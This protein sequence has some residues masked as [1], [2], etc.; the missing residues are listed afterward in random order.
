MFV[1]FRKLKC[2]KISY[3]LNP[4]AMKQILILSLY[5]II[6]LSVFNSAF[7]QI[8]SQ[9][10]PVMYS[11]LAWEDFN[12][13]GFEDLLLTGRNMDEGVISK[14]YKNNGDGTFTD[15]NADI[16]GVYNGSV[17]WGDYD[18]DGFSDILLTGEYIDESYN[19]IKVSKIY[20]NNG[21]ETFT[22]IN[23]ELTAVLNSS[24]A[25]GDYNNDT[26]PDI[27]LTGNLGSEYFPEGI[28]KIYKNNGDGTFT[29]QTMINLTDV[30]NSS[31]AF[32]DYNNDTYLDI[33]LTGRNNSNEH[34]SLI[35]SN[36]TDGTF[37]E[38]NTA[39]LPGIYKGSVAWNDYNNDGNIDILLAGYYYSGY[40]TL[41]SKIYKN[42]GDSTFSDIDAGLQ[43]VYNSSV[44]W[45][46]YNNDN[47]PDI[48][49]TGNNFSDNTFSKIYKNN[50]DDTFTEQMQFNI[51]DVSYSSATWCDYDN[52]GNLDFIISG[53][54]EC[55]NTKGICKLYKNNGIDGFSSGS[56]EYPNGFHSIETIIKVSKSS[57]SWSDYNNDGN[58]D[59]LLTGEDKDYN[60]FSKIY[61]NN[62]DET[63]SDINAGI[64][65]VIF[66]LTDWDDYNNDTFQDVLFIGEDE[67]D[68]YI[69]KI[70]KNNG[71][72]T[73]VDINAGLQSV[74]QG[75]AV[76]G[77]YNN[78][79]LPDILL[80]GNYYDG[81]QQYIT[82]I[83]KNN[84]NNSFSEI[85]AGL[86]GI[87]GG[88]AKWGD[89]NNDGYLDIFVSGGYNDGTWHPILKL[90]KNNNGNGTF[91]EINI[92]LTEFYGDKIEWC[93]YNNDNYLDILLTGQYNNE[94]LTKLYKNNN[95]NGTFSEIN[96]N[97][98]GV[99]DG[100]IDWGDYNNDGLKDI[101]ITGNNYEKGYIAKIY[102]NNGDD[103]FTEIDT[104]MQ[105]VMNGMAKWGNYNNDSFLDIILTGYNNGNRITEIYRNNGNETFTG[106]TGI[107]PNFTQISESYGAWGDYD[108]NNYQDLIL[109]G[110]AINDSSVTD[111][112]SNFEKEFVKAEI[113]VPVLNQ[114]SNQW[115][116]FNNDGYLDLLLTG[117]N[118]LD[119]PVT[120]IYQ[121]GG[122]SVFINSNISIEGI[123]NSST[124]WADY[125]NDG[126]QDLLIAGKNVQGNYITKLYKNTRNN[127][128][129]EAFIAF[130]GASK[131]KWA[132]V[133]NDNKTDILLFSQNNII[134]YENLGNDAFEYSGKINDGWFSILGMEIWDINNDGLTDVLTDKEIILNTGNSNF[135]HWRTLYTYS[136][137]IQSYDYNNSGLPKLVFKT[138]TVNESPAT[139]FYTVNYPEGLISNLVLPQM[140]D[141]DFLISDWDNDRDLDYILSGKDQSGNPYTQLFKNSLSEPD[142][143]PSS[144]T[145]LNFSCNE[146]VVH[147]SWN[148]ATD[149]ETPQNSLTY[150]CY[151]YEIGG[152]T[153]WHSLSNQGTGINNG[154][155][156]IPKEGNVGHNTS[157]FINGLDVTKKYAWSV[158]AIDYTFEGSP[159][160]PE[161]T[162]RLAPAYTLQPENKT[163]CQNSDVIIRIT[164]TG[165]DTYQ[166]QVNNGTGFTNIENNE[167]YNNATTSDLSINGATLEMNNYQFRCAATT[168]GG[169]TYSNPA[170]LTV[171][172]LILANAGE[173]AGVCV[174]TELQLSAENPESAEGTWSCNV[175]Q[176]TFSDI[177]APDA[178]V[179]NL[180]Q[181]STN[182][183]WKITQDNVCGSNTDIVVITQNPDGVLPD[184]SAKPDGE[185]ELCIGS[186]SKLNT[187]GANNALSYIWEITPS[188]AGIISETGTNVTAYWNSNYSGTASIKVQAENECGTGNWSDNFDVELK[189]IQVHD[190]LQKSETM[191]ISVDSGYNYQWYYNE[192][193]ITGATKQYYYNE[194]L[195]SGNYQIKISFYD[196]CDKL[197]SVFETTESNK[198]LPLDKTITIFP[199]PTD[200]NITIEIDNDYIGSI[201]MII[202]DNLGRKRKENIF[203][204]NQKSIRYNKKLSDLE[205]GTY[206]IEFIFDNI[207]LSKQLIIK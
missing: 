180:P 124:D 136:N 33:L 51:T 142:N 190:I 154:K 134:L 9:F 148:K 172:T 139:I 83:Y 46:D 207:K 167:I 164:T 102:K 48:L 60:I 143:I 166:W 88:D 151:M 13:D 98:T 202:T 199:N 189:D 94:S 107:I 111:I 42:N 177:H 89:Y 150:N 141:K 61:K 40:G 175:Q 20:K 117:K 65:G 101:L 97:I 126:F 119:V 73:F 16:Q 159:F 176:V 147:I 50:G 54:Y 100:S 21:N 205:I 30:H 43:V 87:S 182:L 179:Y 206:L 96:T 35:Y 145:G 2:L 92:G 49:L 58:L 128:F 184:K 152:D 8:P 70:Y 31:V 68:N 91:S 170:V 24:V 133:N 28:S 116:D 173:D 186:T 15:I 62:G 69:T 122:N 39:D 131:V 127:N 47:Y 59:F 174:S 157:W 1:L 77:D 123:Y 105:G 132:D 156:Y 200:G 183:E 130:P 90:Y 34:V 169:T 99:N 197:S 80:T 64:Q 66:G 153:I 37:T 14:I 144:P 6:Q 106:I 5:I 204:K 137:E 67:N 7:S 110:V 193:A 95:G 188:E 165:A 26:Y 22:D 4:H 168:V 53:N 32:G 12:N 196:G 108:K 18:K 158:Q 52:D 29:E 17:A 121:N 104:D 114:G 138:D 192:S 163:I 113:T 71:D 36:N 198:S 185:T 194:N 57:I 82:R 63:F 112:F 79:G 81:S 55:S 23:A 41:I 86:Q 135:D 3:F 160:A 161:D 72:D 191:L 162:F 146:D 74:R 85:N 75:S 171:D 76:W 201:R 178:T 140:K 27:L 25:W 84:G 155:R 195:Q 109:S 44:S 187:A 149:T 11:S 203:Y 120:L 129:Q 10:T 125:N 118:N 56:V 45:G 181:G 103:T 19:K 78:D 93:D 38:L 115:F